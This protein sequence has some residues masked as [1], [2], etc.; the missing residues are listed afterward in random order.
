MCNSA[1]PEG[2][3]PSADTLFQ[4]L[5][6]RSLSPGTPPGIST[7]QQAADIVKRVLTTVH[8]KITN[9]G[10]T[11]LE[12]GCKFG[13]DINAQ[14]VSEE[15]SASITDLTETDLEAFCTKQ[16]SDALYGCAMYPGE[17]TTSEDSCIRYNKDN[18]RNP[19]MYSGDSY[20][21]AWSQY[22]RCL[23]DMADDKCDNAYTHR[24]G[25]VFDKRYRDMKP[26]GK[27]TQ[28]ILQ[29]FTPEC[30]A[31]PKRHCKLADEF[32]NIPTNKRPGFCPQTNANG[33]TAQ[34]TG[35]YRR[36]K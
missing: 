29:T 14:Q 17:G 9:H 31:G 28:Y 32:A 33:A 30:V 36:M 25:E 23:A 5:I 22:H 12:T 10:E 16:K 20:P 21:C 18:G 3:V 34:R 4:T 1:G 7:I 27:S 8:S 2:L 35:L 11:C 26:R 6:P 24:N 19:C 13:P 15:G